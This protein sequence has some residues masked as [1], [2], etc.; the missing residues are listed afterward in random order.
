M[1]FLCL[2]FPFGRICNEIIIFRDSL[3]RKKP[4]NFGS[5][6]GYAAPSRVCARLPGLCAALTMVYAGCS[7]LC[8]DLP[9]LYAELSGVCA[10]LTIVYAALLMLCTEWSEVYAAL[11]MLYAEVSWVY[12]R[13]SVGLLDLFNKL[14]GSV[15]QTVSLDSNPITNY[16]ILFT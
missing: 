7:G 9:M 14:C 4:T 5:W 12:A 13:F 10:D 1:L 11:P 2:V 3:I 8:A 6:E 16:P 15:Q